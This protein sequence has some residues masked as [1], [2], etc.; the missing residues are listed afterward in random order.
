[1]S[2][3]RDMALVSEYLFVLNKAKYF[4]LLFGNELFVRKGICS[5]RKLSSGLNINQTF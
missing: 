5:F 1:M 4:I 2:K 3:L